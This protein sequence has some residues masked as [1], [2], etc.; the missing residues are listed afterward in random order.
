MAKLSIFGS[1]TNI[2]MLLHTLLKGKRVGSDGFGNKY[3]RGKPRRGAVRERRWVI[4]PKGTDAS[5]VPA[6]W[7][8]W[9]HHQTDRVPTA[10]GNVYRKPWQKEHLSNQSGTPAAYLPPGKTG[11]RPH[12]TGDYTAWQPP[13]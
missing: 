12:A 8:G 4:Y 3:Y 1:L 6:E 9:L 7:H 5:V 13:Q 11:T 10:E 2:Q